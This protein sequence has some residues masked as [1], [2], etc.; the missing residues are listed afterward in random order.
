MSP[1]ELRFDLDLEK[2]INVED[3]TV[4]KRLLQDV[5]Q[6]IIAH[7]ELIDTHRDI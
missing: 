4:R 3:F 1:R 7:P 5:V 2:I 6:M